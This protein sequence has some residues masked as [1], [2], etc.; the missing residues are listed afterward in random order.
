MCHV[1]GRCFGECLEALFGQDRVVRND[2]QADIVA[3]RGAT[4]DG[5]RPLRSSGG[6]RRLR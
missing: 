3:A 2:D 6:G 4:P 5:G 1:S